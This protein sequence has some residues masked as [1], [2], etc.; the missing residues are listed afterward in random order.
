M[1]DYR[2]VFCDVILRKFLEVRQPGVFPL[3]LG[4]MWFVLLAMTHN[5][6]EKIR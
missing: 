6:K 5:I 4:M 3:H 1:F 2:I